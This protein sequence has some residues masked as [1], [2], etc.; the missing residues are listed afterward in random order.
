MRSGW[1]SLFRAW[2]ADLVTRVWIAAGSYV[3]TVW[4][5]GLS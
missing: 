1:L 5:R 3:C 4:D 2:T